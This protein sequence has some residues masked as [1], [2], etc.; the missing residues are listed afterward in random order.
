MHKFKTGDIIIAL[1]SKTCKFNPRTEGEAYRVLGVM[2]CPQC[3]EDF[4]CIN[5]KHYDQTV[6]IKCATCG[7][8]DIYSNHVWTLASNFRS[9]NHFDPYDELERAVK[10]EDYMRAA[11]LRD[12]INSDHERQRQ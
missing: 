10:N 7:C 2:Q 5:E 6:R 4:V 1:N 8:K 9:E 12:M 3:R 11:E